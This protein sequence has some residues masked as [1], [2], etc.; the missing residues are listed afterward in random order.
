[1]EKV[2]TFR[3]LIDTEEENDVFRDIEIRSSSDFI[4]LHE[5]IQQAFSFDNSQMASFYISDQSWERGQEIA[6]MDMGMD[7][8]LYSMTG[9][10]LTEFLQEQG[11]RT[12][13]VFD[14]LLMWTFFVELVRISDVDPSADYPRIALSVGD[15]PDQYSKEPEDLFGAM[16][17]F[18]EDGSS[19]E[20]DPSSDSDS[21]EDLKDLY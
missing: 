16:S 11:N 4:V 12:L 7:D 3:V 6:L 5:A 17:A 14:F 9:T 1:M 2:Y 18:P 19:E 10:P 21:E 8:S 13:Y 20:G 15:S